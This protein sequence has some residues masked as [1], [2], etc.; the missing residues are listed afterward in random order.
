[1]YFLFEPYYH[2]KTAGNHWPEF[3]YIR[4]TY[5]KIIFDLEQ[6]YHTRVYAVKS[7]HFLIN[8]LN[9]INVPMQYSPERYVEACRARLNGVVREQR[10]TS[11]VSV[12]QLH[13]GVFYGEGCSEILLAADTFFDIDEVLV[14]WRNT[15]AVKP[16]WHPKSDM[17]FLLPNGKT[18][19]T[20]TGL[21]VMEIDLAKLS[22]QYR[23][24]SLDQWAKHSE[25]DSLLGAAH[26]IHMYVLPNLLGQQADIA[27]FNRLL[28]LYYGRPMGASLAKHAVSIS[29]Y[30]DKTDRVLNKVIDYLL[31]S[32]HSQAQ[33]LG[34]IPTVLRDNAFLS[35]KMPDFPPT[36]QVWWAMLLSRLQ[37]MAFLLD[38]GKRNGTNE[39]SRDAINEIQINLKRLNRENVLQTAVP[40]DLLF[41]ITNLIDEILA[42]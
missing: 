23:Q 9:T 3:D 5:L 14:N 40:R 37:V 13:K 22:L 32:K 17:G 42:Y 2:E 19:S 24:F 10:M 18:T 4:R 27:I 26:F 21:A 12:G 29:N 11:E 7:N 36:R 39:L 35:L 41:D 1:M 33:V 20:G 34:L 38:I 25:K 8:A 31:T 30:N 6:Y 15:V 16:L 28:N